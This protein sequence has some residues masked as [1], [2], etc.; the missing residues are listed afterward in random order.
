MATNFFEV[1]F[2][3]ALLF[4]VILLIIKLVSKG[5]ERKEKKATALL[6]R[7]LVSSDEAYTHIGAYYA[8]V[9]GETGKQ[10]TSVNIKFA[11][12]KFLQLF[13][14]GYD[15]ASRE[16]LTRFCNLKNT[17]CQTIYK[18]V[19][20]SGKPMVIQFNWS[21]AN[22]LDS[23]ER[24]AYVG[25]GFDL[26]EYVNDKSFSFS[27][28]VEI[29]F[30][31]D[32]PFDHSDILDIV[33]MIRLCEVQRVT[34]E[35]TVTRA[36][37]FRMVVSGGK[38]RIVP[39][40][41]EIPMQPEEYLRA[42]YSQ[43]GVSFNGENVQLDMGKALT[44]AVEALK[45]EQNLY[46]LGGPGVGKTTLVDQLQVLLS[47]DSEMDINIV[48]IT[49]GI[50]QELQ[51]AAAQ[52]DFITAIQEL[53]EYGSQLT[54]LI[55]DEAETLLVQE[56]KGI[57]SLNNTLML[58]LLAGSLQKDLGIV[59]VLIFNARP[60]QLNQNLFRNGR[61]GLIYDLSPINREQAVELANQLKAK[62]PEK[63]FDNGAFT[64]YLDNESQ[65]PD[66]TVYSKAGEITLADVYACFMD[67]DR[68]SLLVDMLREMS[69][70][71]KQIDSFPQRGRNRRPGPA[72]L[73][74]IMPISD[75][76][77][78]VSE[79]APPVIAPR[80]ARPPKLVAEIAVPK[81]P[82]PPVQAV[83]PQGPK[84]THK[85]HHKRKKKK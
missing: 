9:T 24:I 10:A 71:P 6:L 57:H 4:A 55:I 15:A 75:M 43:V 38:Y 77:D 49:P 58:Q 37:V 51:T 27:N 25:E 70:R 34:Y 33:D 66:G 32:V 21:E 62:F 67:R 68:K 36:K 45:D 72:R 23:R 76:A 1:V 60:E 26:S 61:Q 81:A 63:A 48:A 8:T 29:M 59:S 22:Y 12:D 52:G 40:W 54:V 46:L 78:V 19:G 53:Q 11:A 64:K 17:S 30:S 20:K 14:A 69:G 5:F 16:V 56:Q 31:A 85:G 73:P 44:F 39:Q 80:P 41:R 74:K 84:H 82:P 18:V 28:S 47:N 50:M 7:A 42:A 13:E 35:S 65:F 2:L 3:L 83:Q 79:S